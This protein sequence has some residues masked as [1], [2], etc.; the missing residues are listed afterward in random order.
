MT[1]ETGSRIGPYQ[2]E[3]TLG[4]G[5]MGVVYRGYHTRLERRVAIKVLKGLEHDP[6]ALKRF[7]REAKAMAVLQHPNILEVFDFG[8]VDEAPY[9]VMEYLPG[10]TLL[11]RIKAGSLDHAEAIRI[12][13]GVAAA[14][15]F[16]A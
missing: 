11:D 5:G 2:I 8:E 7:E 14:L 16:A 3:A 13:R 6:I 12:L 1:I 9:M 10:G 4:H 15:D